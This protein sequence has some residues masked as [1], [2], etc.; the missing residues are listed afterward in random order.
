MSRLF[1]CLM[2]LIASHASAKAATAIGTE[3]GGTVTSQQMNPNPD[4][5]RC[6]DNARYNSTPST[7]AGRKTPASP[8]KRQK[9]VK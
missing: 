7:P 5:Q 6:Y 8:R 1:V 4:R 3:C 9:A 2:L